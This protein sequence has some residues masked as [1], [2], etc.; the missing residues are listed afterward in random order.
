MSSSVF[1]ESERVQYS[2]KKACILASYDYKT[3]RVQKSDEGKFTV[4]P[5]SNSL[6]FKTTTRIPRVGCMLVGWGGNN[7]STVTACVLANKLGVSWRT[8]QGTRVSPFLQNLII[9]ICT[10]IYNIYLYIIPF[11]IQHANYYGSITQSSTTSLGIGPD[12][13]DVYVPLKDL[14][15]MI[16]PNDIEFDGMYNIY[17]NH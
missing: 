1:I 17:S 7:G 5:V 9:N 4:T 6:M 3:T 8:K 12:G 13:K 10:I 15:P 14:L 11:F 2:S 16:N